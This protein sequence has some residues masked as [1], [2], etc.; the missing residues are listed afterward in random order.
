MRVS[1]FH[2][3]SI[4]S[5]H[6]SDSRA[7]QVAYCNELGSNLQSWHIR[8][9][10]MPRMLYK[11]EHVQCKVGLNPLF[12]YATPRIRRR[13]DCLTATQVGK[14]CKTCNLQRWEQLP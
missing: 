5:I 12:P 4:D 13:A 9:A 3:A 2:A 8:N 1:Y 7:A 14:S 11:E 6:P 10:T